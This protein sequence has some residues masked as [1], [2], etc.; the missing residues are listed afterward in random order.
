MYL[1][2]SKR[3]IIW[4]WGSTSLIHLG[5]TINSKINIDPVLLTFEQYHIHQHGSEFATAII[6]GWQEI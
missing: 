5:L 3:L 2:K 1:E 4:N 6:T